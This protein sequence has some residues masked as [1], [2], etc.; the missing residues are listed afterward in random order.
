MGF[1]LV[2]KSVILNDLQRR[3]G[4]VVCVISPNSVDLG[5]YYVKVVVVVVVYLHDNNQ[6]SY[7]YEHNHKLTPCKQ[8]PHRSSQ[9]I[10]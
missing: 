2:P 8:G 4:R 7:R 1:S 10:F 6:I 5:L 3:N 9:L